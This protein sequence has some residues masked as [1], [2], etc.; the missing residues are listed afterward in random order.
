MRGNKLSDLLNN[1]VYWPFSAPIGLPYTGWAKSHATFVSPRMEF[2]RQTT[3]SQ[4]SDVA[5]LLAYLI[6]RAK[7]APY[8]VF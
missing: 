8:Q 5:R 6:F 2:S 7:L 3:N 1:C 4:K